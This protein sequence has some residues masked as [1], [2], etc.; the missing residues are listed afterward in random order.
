MSN[1]EDSLNL[2]YQ[3]IFQ[4]H[5]KYDQLENQYRAL[6]KTKW[7]HYQSCWKCMFKRCKQ[8]KKLSTACIDK[9]T[10]VV[11]AWKKALDSMNRGNL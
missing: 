7:N 9:E 4:A 1:S 3:R 5:Q 6:N 2:F 8:F 11:K 10:Q